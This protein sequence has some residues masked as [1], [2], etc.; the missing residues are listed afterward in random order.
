MAAAEQVSVKA[1]ARMKTARGV[2]LEER[3]NLG[4]K[5]KSAKE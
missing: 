5:G 4:S 1:R 3:I 2:Q